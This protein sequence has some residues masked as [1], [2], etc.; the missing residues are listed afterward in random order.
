MFFLVID[1]NTFEIYVRIK[2]CMTN[3]FDHD[4]ILH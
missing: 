1:S 4:S 2:T 3:V